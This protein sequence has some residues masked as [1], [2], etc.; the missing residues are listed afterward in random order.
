MNWSTTTNVPGTRS[1][2]SDPTADSETTSVTPTRLSAWMLARKFSSDGGTR[3][4]RPWRG[5]KTM[6][7]PSSVPN[8][9]SSDGLP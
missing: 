8:M 7:N 9:S 4:P 2:R 6:G 5:K 1:S 3:W